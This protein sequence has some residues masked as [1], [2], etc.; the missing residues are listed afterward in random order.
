MQLKKVQLKFSRVRQ[1]EE[2]CEIDI[3][4]PEYYSP[5]TTEKV[6]YEY[7]LAHGKWTEQ[8]EMNVTG[9]AIIKGEAKP[10]CSR[11]G[12]DHHVSDCE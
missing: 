10:V 8:R 9:V 12:G 11:C 7:A 2:H 5:A 1:I 4:V 6:A 3:S